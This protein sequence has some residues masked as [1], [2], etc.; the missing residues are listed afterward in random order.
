MKTISIAASRPYDVL[1]GPGLLQ[2]LGTH[3][4]ALD[5]AKV[6]ALVTDDTVDKR[7]GAQAEASIRAAGLD[8][9]KFVFPHG[10]ASKCAAT[11]LQLLEFLA[12]NHLTRTDVLAAL[13][14]GVVGD[15]A[16]FAAATYRRGIRF[17]QVPTTL[18]AA[19]DSSVG[20]KTAIDLPQGKNLAG[21]FWQPSLVLC[22]SDIIA[23]LPQ[24]VLQDGCGEVA[25]YGMLGGAELFC[26]LE[27]QPIAIHLEEII[28][29]CVA[30]KQAVV[31]ADEFERGER[32]LLNFGHTFG[33]AVE[34]CSNFTISHGRAVAIGMVM[35]TRAAVKN[36]LCPAD[37]L[38]RL[39]S[40]LEQYHLPHAAQ[41]PAEALAHAILSDK[42]ITGNTI[43]LVLPAEI[44][45]CMLHPV[46][47]AELGEW[48][49]KGVL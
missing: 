40:L 28:A 36:G 23:D 37:C 22:D 38:P 5:K 9:K 42:K 39:I 1:I 14:G 33:H 13:G 20:G 19:V 46:P 6:C 49:R 41:I 11:Y 31:Q 27:Q 8:V 34:A 48:T 26:A 45:R 43:T 32:Q 4:T 47:I 24:D 21:A 44:G 29:Q 30:L 7:Y 18:L 2:T 3:L 10:E 12:S 35:A 17:V 15:L 16:G 25:K